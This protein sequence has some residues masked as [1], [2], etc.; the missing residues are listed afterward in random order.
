[1]YTI[2][3]IAG[4]VKISNWATL[5]GSY[6]ELDMEM[7]PVIPR[8]SFTY[9]T[10]QVE[11]RLEDRQLSAEEV[12][13]NGATEK[14]FAWLMAQNDPPIHLVI[15]NVLEAMRQANPRFRDGAQ[16]LPET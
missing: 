4:Y 3:I 8:L 5:K 14:K 13:Q 16:N 1:F 15:E 10:T 2:A 7:P 6:Q 12:I 9:V 11:K